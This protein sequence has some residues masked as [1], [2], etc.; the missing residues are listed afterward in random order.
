[1]R[2]FFSFVFR[3]S[4]HRWPLETIRSQLN[5]KY[6]I[7]NSIINWTKT[8]QKKNA[9]I[10]IIV[11]LHFTAPRSRSSCA[12]SF[13]NRKLYSVFSFRT[14]FPCH[15]DP[16]PLFSFLLNYISLL[17]LG[18]TPGNP[19]NLGDSGWRREIRQTNIANILRSLTWFYLLILVFVFINRATPKKKLG[20]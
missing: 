4:M 8:N 13:S 9:R 5:R 16:S 14:S 18:E 11:S 1:M 12:A 2:F 7:L 20:D 19:S 17:H 15:R 3:H 10:N 6:I